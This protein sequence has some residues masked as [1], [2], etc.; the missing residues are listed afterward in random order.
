MPTRLDPA[1]LYVR[2]LPGA[3]HDGPAT[4]RCYTLT[5]S[6]RTRELFLTIGATFDRQQISGL[7]TQLMRDEVLAEWMLD[8]GR[9][10]LHVFCHVSGGLALGSAGWRERILRKHLP[11]ALEALRYGD[12]LLFAARPELDAA[13]LLIHFAAR[14][15]RYRCSEQWQTAGAY[16]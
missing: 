16:R 4:P 6:D 11:L 13:P 10:A 9:P 12:R 2:Y 5:H 8:D 3:A 15:E 14:Q 1:K 7:Y